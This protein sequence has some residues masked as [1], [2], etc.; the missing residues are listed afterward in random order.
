VTAPR[1]ARVYDIERDRPA[2]ELREWSDTDP[3]VAMLLM[4]YE[5][6]A[7]RTERREL[8]RKLAKGLLLAGGCWL[9]AVGV[10]LWK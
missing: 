5:R 4:D 7:E 2:P 9:V 1:T 8:V 3:R 10:L 6:E